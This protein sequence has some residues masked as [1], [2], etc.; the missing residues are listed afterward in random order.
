[1]KR[2]RLFVF[3]AGVLLIFCN[4]A[5]SYAFTLPD[6]GQTTCSDANG[7]VIACAGTGQDAAHIVNPMSYTDNGN[8]T[9]TDNVTGLMWQKQDDGNQYNWYQATAT[10][11]AY[12]NP[13]SQSVCGVLSL[14]GYSDWRLPAVMELMSIVNYSIP[15]P[16]PTTNTTYFP[17]TKANGNGYW[18]STSVDNISSNAW[19]LDFSSGIV[20]S[21]SKGI[22][23]YYVRCVRG[24]QEPPSF[25][26]NG[27]GTVTD[28]ATG[29]MWQQVE[30]APGYTWTNALSYC[31]VLNLGGNSDWRLPNIRELTS[32][33][34]YSK[35]RPSINTIFFP[36]AYVFL[37]W[38]STSVSGSARTAWFVD[39]SNGVVSYPSGGKSGNYVLRCVRGGRSDS[40]AAT[41][42][43]DFKVHVPIV[44]YNG[45]S[46]SADFQWDGGLSVILTNLTQLNDISPFGSCTPA[47]VSSDLILHVPVIMY[48]GISYWANVQ[49]NTKGLPFEVIGVGRN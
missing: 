28:S 31:N 26:D 40:C 48:N 47:T 3:F 18:S 20:G 46:Y 12:Y 42:S 32:I 19:G 8:G 1:M 21:L 27:N 24:G 39:F 14:G 30:P 41:V 23:S 45:N 13:S 36:N 34:D 17:D 7:N 22:G 44:V 25:T 38:S 43:S 11:D 37:Y 29:L 49:C 6:T 16:G 5:P 10:Y 4:C 35:D 33:V 2:Q 15:S 9:V